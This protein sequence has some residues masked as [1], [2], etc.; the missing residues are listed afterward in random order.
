MNPAVDPLKKSATVGDLKSLVSALAGLVRE[1]VREEVMAQLSE[2]L[3]A[4][5]TELEMLPRLDASP[6]L[7]N[8]KIVK[9]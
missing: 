7:A 6:R 1:S 5:K 2:P 8:G 3:H 9:P 4:M